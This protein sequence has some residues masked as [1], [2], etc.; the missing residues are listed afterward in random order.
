M[1]NYLPKAHGC[2]CDAKLVV[3]DLALDLVGRRQLLLEAVAVDQADR[4]GAVAWRDQ[5]GQLLALVADPAKDRGRVARARRPDGDRWEASRDGG[6]ARLGLAGREGDGVDEDPLRGRGAVLGLL[7][8]R[9]QGGDG[10]VLVGEA[11][12][13]HLGRIVGLFQ[14]DVYIFLSFCQNF[15]DFVIFCRF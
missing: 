5:R 11:N 4:A 1:G 12:G 9:I 3:A 8:D 10:D 13:G 6:E 2:L 14:F 15:C 7:H